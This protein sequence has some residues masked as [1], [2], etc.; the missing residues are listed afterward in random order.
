MRLDHL[1]SKELLSTTWLTRAGDSSR[2]PVRHSLF[3]HRLER[4]LVPDSVAGVRL[5]RFEGAVSRCL[6]RAAGLAPASFA[7]PAPLENC[8]ASTSILLMFVHLIFLNVDN[9]S[10]EEPTVDA[11]ALTTEEGRERLR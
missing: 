6:E 7:F 1:L 5:F 11:L 9:P 8:I 2:F 10:Y 4:D 3:V